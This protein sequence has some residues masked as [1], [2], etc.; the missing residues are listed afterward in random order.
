M[1]A[2][3]S[4][5]APVRRG[6]GLYLSGVLLRRLGL[7]VVVF[8]AL[9]Y[10]LSF[11]HAGLPH[12]T[13]ATI[14]SAWAGHGTCV[15]QQYEVFKLFNL[16]RFK[17]MPEEEIRAEHARQ[18][19]GPD[20]VVGDI[21]L[22]LAWNDHAMGEHKST[23]LVSAT[24]AEKLVARGRLRRD[25]IRI[26]YGSTARDAPIVVVQ[27]IEASRRDAGLI[28]LAGAALALPGFALGLLWRW[29][30]A[31]RGR[32][33]GAVNEQA[34]AISGYKVY[35]RAYDQEVPAGDLASGQETA[36][37]R[38]LLDARLQ[39]AFAGV[40]EQ[41]AQRLDRCVPASARSEALVAILLDNSGSLRGPP[42]SSVASP[43]PVSGDC[44]DASAIM[45]LACVTDVLVAA[46]EQC[47][48]KAEVL[49]FTTVEWKGGRSRRDWLADGRPPN[50]GRLNDLRHIVYKEA[51]STGRAARQSFGA[52]LDAS[53]L[54]ENIDGEALA[55]AHGRLQARPER[56]RILMMI[57]DGPPT[58]DSTLSVNTGNYLE[59]HLRQVIEAI[60]TRS[61]IELIAIG[62]GLDV[63]RYYR[64]AVSITDPA[65]L[66]GA[67]T[68]KLCE[69]IAEDAREAP[70]LNAR[71]F[72]SQ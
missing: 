17:D 23:V 54:K 63:S 36:R 14:E 10:G 40:G 6:T 49:G 59:M 31:P 64:R 24:T 71:N 72:K 42:G 68:D 67:V 56:R 34:T 22:A 48:I 20:A 57:S 15:A 26:R 41:V 53:L 13:V 9:R 19:A 33:A 11:M 16:R 27:E 5:P 28:A 37:R 3:A 45:L 7:L 39:E 43:M 47:G 66:A 18:C 4:D 46:L 30:S 70:T 51:D 21:Y 1:A 2:P 69:L 50:P 52:M 25:A 55:W 44:G 32:G 62:I 61:P 8:G 65:E 58:D 29:R 38:R 60:E 12:E 35:Q